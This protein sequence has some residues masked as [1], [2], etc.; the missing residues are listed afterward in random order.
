MTEITGGQALARQLVAEGVT[1]IFGLPGDQIMHALDGIYDE[2]R[3]RWITTRHEQG[4]TYM[5]DGYARTSGRPGVAFVV[6]GVGVYNA[7]AGL[8]TAYAASSPVVLI[9]GQVNRQGIGKSLGLLHELHDQLDVVRP[10]TAWQ[11]RSLTAGEIPATVHEAFARVRRGRRRPV[12]VEF[13]PEAFSESANVELIPAASEV[14]ETADPEQIA[15][16]AAI[17]DGAKRPLIWAGGGVVLGDASA[18]LTALAEFLQA[19]VVTTRQGKGAIDDR[20]PL[21]I[22]TMWVNRRLRPVLDD[23]DVIL[24]VGTHFAG[25][26]VG[27]DKQVVHVDVDEAEIGRQHPNSFPVI[28]DAASTLEALLDELRKIGDPRPDRT[29]ETRRQRSDVENQLRSIG[30]QARYVELLRQAIPQNGVL[31]PCT[32]TVGYMCHMHYAVYEPRTYVS[33]SYMGTLGSAFPTALGAK[34][35]RPDRPVV[36]VSGDGGFLFAATELATAMQYGINT[37][38]I[39]FNDNAYGNS[40]RDQRERF[41]GREIGTELRNPDFALFAAAFGADGVKLRDAEHLA[42]ALPE[43]IDNNRPTVIEVPMERLPSPF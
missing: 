42:A 43:A 28:G 31:V 33:T 19:G 2:P 15:S 4:T 10:I 7:G 38:T 13:P 24:A 1:D 17:L 35:G 9:A 21:S 8:A 6:P 30:P 5:A 22:G 23:A 27:S 40:N 29:I 14:R 41:D 32:T 26:G 16:A 25:S 12:E 34:V 3:L 39:V 20:H 11:R 37:V 36:C 18:Q